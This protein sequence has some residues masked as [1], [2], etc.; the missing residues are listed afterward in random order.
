[1]TALAMVFP[2]ALQ[3]SKLPI[4]YLQPVPRPTVRI[5]T[6]M[7]SKCAAQPK[8]RRTNNQRKIVQSFAAVCKGIP[9][10]YNVK[11]FV[12]EFNTGLMNS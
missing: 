7:I 12:K 11:R 9:K 10:K 8:P 2:S 6:W 3:T 5:E 1:M 4:I